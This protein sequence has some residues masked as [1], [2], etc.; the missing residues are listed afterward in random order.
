MHPWTKSIQQALQLIG[1]D[2]DAKQMQAYMRDQ[3]SFFGIKSTTRRD[4]VKLLFTKEQR[5]TI[6]ELSNVV[7][8]LWALPEREY[9]MVA[10]DLLIKNKRQLTDD[11]LPD[12]ERW[13]TQK[14]WWDTVDMLATHI[15]GQLYQSSPDTTLQY[16][17]KWQNADNIWLRRTTI[18]YQLKFKAKTDEIKLFSIIKK[19]QHDTEFFIQKAIGWALRE[20]SKTNSQTVIDFIASNNITGLAKRE[21]LKWILKHEGQ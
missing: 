7:N 9:Q 14:S 1:N 4:A 13:I 15:I 18:L 20:Y 19:N 8:E 3:F 6:G 10:I 11:M 2:G 12:I 16:I 5:P 17:E 21:G